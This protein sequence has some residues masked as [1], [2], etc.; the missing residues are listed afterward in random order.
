MNA[1]DP[2]EEL[3][4]KQ[5]G[6]VISLEEMQ[7]ITGGESEDWNLINP[8]GPDMPT[9]DRRNQPHTTDDGIAFLNVRMTLMA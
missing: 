3:N 5:Q 7:S 6:R 1:V 9:F 4:M 2:K 8:V